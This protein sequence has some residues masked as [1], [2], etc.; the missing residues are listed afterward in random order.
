[1]KKLSLFILGIFIF[2]LVIVDVKARQYEITCEYGLSETYIVYTIT[3]RTSGTKIIKMTECT[4]TLID[5]ETEDCSSMVFKDNSYT[6][7]AEGN[8]GCPS[9]ISPK[10]LDTLEWVSSYG[11]DYPLQRM[12]S[13]TLIGGSSC[14][15]Y[16][17]SKHCLN[18]SDE[19][20]CVWTENE[21]APQGGFCNVDNLLYVGCGGASDI[22]QKFSTIISLAVNIF[23]IV[24]PLIL[25]FTGMVSLIKSL[26]T[27]KE[28]EIK[29]AQTALIRKVIATVLVYFTISIVQFAISKVASDGEEYE[30]FSNCLNCFINNDCEKSTYYRT[31]VAGTDFCT[32]L[33]TGIT[34][35]CD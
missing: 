33:T 20:E 3:F 16:T 17:N 25:I 34:S 4:K 12:S 23:K 15:D 11:G 27:Q 28:D 32:P 19:V 8:S 26:A 18:T 24:A 31:T 35:E 13:K 22:P 30:S 2:T 1:M 7:Q 5:N 10:G 6:T 29:K 21:K 9:S 14:T